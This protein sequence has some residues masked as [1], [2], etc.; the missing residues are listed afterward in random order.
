MD[1]VI[2]DATIGKYGGFNYKIENDKITTEEI[3]L[4]NIGE[5]TKCRPTVIY[6]HI[7][8]CIGVNNT[9][10]DLSPEIPKGSK[11]G[12][13]ND[14]LCWVYYINNDVYPSYYAKKIE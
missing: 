2:W 1:T 13:D 9:T 8:N 12:W 11:Y 6:S 10:I 4:E 14:N 5:I 7:N 3:K